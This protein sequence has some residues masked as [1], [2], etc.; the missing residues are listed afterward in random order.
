MKSIDG[1]D[2]LLSKNATLNLNDL[3]PFNVAPT[4]LVIAF[5]METTKISSLYDFRLKWIDKI[6]FVLRRKRRFVSIKQF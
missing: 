4:E 5:Y 6:T 2:F 1:L 3:G